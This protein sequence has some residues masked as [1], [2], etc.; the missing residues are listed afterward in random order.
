MRPGHTRSPRSQP[1]RRCHHPAGA[2]HFYGPDAFFSQFVSTHSLTCSNVCA[3]RLRHFSREFQDQRPDN[4]IQRHEPDQ[5]DEARIEDFLDPALGDHRPVITG[6]HSLFVSFLFECFELAQV[7]RE[8]V[9]Q[10]RNRLAGPCV[11]LS[12]ATARTGVPPMPP[13]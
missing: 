4:R 11:A 7:G 12:G 5:F 3:F 6:G 10:E 13:P 8:L 9:G 1:G 2:C